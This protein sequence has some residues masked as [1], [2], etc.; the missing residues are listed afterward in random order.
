MGFPLFPSMSHHVL[1]Q[2][3]KTRLALVTR[4]SV[5]E[6][7]GLTPL[8]LRQSSLNDSK[9]ARKACHVCDADLAGLSLTHVRTLQSDSSQQR[10]LFPTLATFPTNTSSSSTLARFRNANHSSALS[11]NFSNF[12]FDD[13]NLNFY[14]HCAG[15]GITTQSLVNK[16]AIRIDAI[17]PN[18]RF[19]PALS[20][21]LQ[22]L[23]MQLFTA[24]LHSDRTLRRPTMVE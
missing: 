24:L 18:K 1:A 2:A 7:F 8:N 4:A 16:P 10:K 15:P 23:M 22:Q 19:Y 5:V 9:L 11:F 14:F 20:V 17:E 3:S 21:C 13:D 12:Q 6:K